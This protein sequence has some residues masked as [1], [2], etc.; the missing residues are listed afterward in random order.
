MGRI[1]R[2]GEAAPDEKNQQILKDALSAG[3]YMT[4]GNTAAGFGCKEDIWGE[5]FWGI[6]FPL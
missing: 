2:M 1:P 5:G 3:C 6:S 4:F